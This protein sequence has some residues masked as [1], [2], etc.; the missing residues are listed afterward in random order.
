MP[1]PE[2]AV[3]SIR[4]ELAFRNSLRLVLRH[5]H[6]HTPTAGLGEGYSIFKLAQAPAKHNAATNGSTR[7]E[8]DRHPLLPAA[9]TLA[10]IRRPTW[11]AAAPFCL[12][13]LRPL[14]K[15]L[16]AAAHPRRRQPLASSFARAP[17]LARRLASPN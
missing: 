16:D 17:A 3:A 7:L 6:T 8:P 15:Y 2:P 9:L 4:G 14:L 13:P 11:K 1:P 5:T 10:P 12:A